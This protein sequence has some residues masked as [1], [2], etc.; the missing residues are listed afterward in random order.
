MTAATIPAMRA[1]TPAWVCD[2]PLVKRG[3][4]IGPGPLGAG[5]AGY[6][7]MAAALGGGGGALTGAAEG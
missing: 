1:M 4:L 5:A 6:A 3:D 2:A 7:G